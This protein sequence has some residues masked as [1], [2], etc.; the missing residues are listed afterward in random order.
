MCHKN[1][2]K[3]H[4]VKET[5]RSRASSVPASLLSRMQHCDW[6]THCKGD[7]Q[8]GVIG[9]SISQLARWSDRTVNQS[10][11]HYIFVHLKVMD[12]QLSLP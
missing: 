1:V 12:S 5:F 7:W 10:E 2:F 3:F 4:V 9:Q 8:G 11:R 6:L